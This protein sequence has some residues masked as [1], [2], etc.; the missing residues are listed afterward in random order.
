MNNK[1]YIEEDIKFIKAMIEEYKTF[2][3]LDNPEF[4]NTDKIY[5]ALE[6]ILADREKY[7]R[8]AEQ[9]LKDSEEFKNNMCEHRCVKNTEIIELQAKAN[10]YDSLVENIKKDLIK[11]QEEYEILLEH[12]SGQESNRTKYLRGKIHMCQ[13]L[14]DTEK[15]KI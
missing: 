5:K 10:K 12:Q 13:E 3:D 8:L 9:N 6:N 4:E 14:L 11:L 7:K 15:E 1:K 2:K